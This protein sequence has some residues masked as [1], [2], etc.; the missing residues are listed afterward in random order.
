MTATSLRLGFLLSFLGAAA[1]AQAPPAP[2]QLGGLSHQ[3]APGFQADPAAGCAIVRYWPDR[4]AEERRDCAAPRPPLRGPV[5]EWLETP[6]AISLFPAQLASNGPA[7]PVLVFGARGTAVVKTADP[8]AAVDFFQLDSFRAV[9]APRP[10]FRR[11]VA[12]A[13]AA[14]GVAL[15]AGTVAAAVRGQGGVLLSRPARLEPGATLELQPAPPAPGKA[16]LLLI[17]PR[18]RDLRFYDRDHEVALSLHRGQGE[19]RQPDL[20][21]AGGERL[22]AFFYDL[23]SGNWQ[24][25]AK[26]AA[27]ELDGPSVE[28]RGGQ[29]KIATVDLVP[30]PSLTIR[31]EMPPGLRSTP[32]V[33]D[34]SDL[35]T[36]EPLTRI[37]GIDPRSEQIY[38][39]FLPPVE[40]ALDFE[41]DAWQF[42]EEADLRS[43]EDVV[44]TFAPKPIAVSGTITRDGQPY[45][46]YITFTPGSVAVPEATPT[47]P[48]GRYETTLYKSGFYPVV[49]EMGDR[50]AYIRELIVPEVAELTLD[51]DVPANDVK[52]VVAD[53]QSGDAIPQPHIYLEVPGE[54][55]PQKIAFTAGDDG[56]LALPP[57]PP[58]Q[59]SL[60]ASAEGYL[61]SPPQSYE[62]AQLGREHEI[63]ILL[64]K[65]SEPKTIR[66]QRND[67]QPAPNIEVRAQPGLDDSLPSFEGWTN[68]RGE[69][70]IPAQADALYLLWRDPGG[71]L[72]SGFAMYQTEDPRWSNPVT[73]APAARLV[74]RVVDR[75][76]APL[77]DAA[78][79]M[80]EN[81]ERVEGEALVFLHGTRASDPAGYLRAK[82]LPPA[83]LGLLA[84]GS[85]RKYIELESLAT[86]IA[87]PWPAVIQLE[88]AE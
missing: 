60:A 64:E 28:L 58:G 32:M 53:G 9:R 7:P 74:A 85:G 62:V 42:H 88:R 10:D 50:P 1:F 48:G 14:Q 47:D 2:L 17:L 16:D 24:V 8:A 76:G 61:R 41:Y 45:A 86:Q 83:Q 56:T 20:V 59:V 26:S 79:M 18:H 57:L 46:T 52:V 27:Y 38:L 55:R 72:A 25:E 77:A 23:P 3:A 71:Q 39:G 31:L 11:R 35:A 21:A 29:A 69:V 54:N 15:P 73:L 33:L 37:D 51:F 87:W 30:R 12:A 43:R 75:S 13:E 65:A 5:L 63:R 34:A 19:P 78:L 70:E 44:I 6:A 66:F 84:Y 4:Q 80:W 67:G 68:A 22:L 40:V 81:G 36:G 82:G 49:I